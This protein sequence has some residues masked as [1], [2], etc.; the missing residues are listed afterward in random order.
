MKIN[1]SKL[2]TRSSAR[3]YLFWRASDIPIWLLG[4]DDSSEISQR[5]L[6]GTMQR[7]D[8]RISKFHGKCIV[9]HEAEIINLIEY[10][11][12]PD[13][14]HFSKVYNYWTRNIFEATPISKCPKM[15][16][17][18]AE[19][20]SPFGYIVSETASPHFCAACLSLV[21]KDHVIICLGCCISY[22][23][24]CITPQIQNIKRNSLRMC[25]KCSRNLKT[26]TEQKIPLR[27]FIY[28]GEQSDY[29]TLTGS[30]APLIPETYLPSN[31]L[32]P[33]YTASIPS[34]SSPQSSPEEDDTILSSPPH[35]PV[36][37]DTE[38]KTFERSIDKYSD[39][40]ST[41][42]KLLPHKS[43]KNVV[44]FYFKW[45]AKKRPSAI[46]SFSKYRPKSSFSS[47]CESRSSSPPKPPTAQVII[48]VQK[49]SLKPRIECSNC[50]SKYAQT[51]RNLSPFSSNKNILCSSCA[52]YFLRYALPPK[53]P[54]DLLQKNKL[55]PHSNDKRKSP[56]LSVV[57]HKYKKSLRIA[58]KRSPSP[59]S[60][61]NDDDLSDLDQI[62][63][64]RLSLSCA[65]CLSQAG[66]LISCSFCSM[67]V[68]P[69]CFGARDTSPF[70]CQKCLNEIHHTSP[71]SYECI[72]CPKSLAKIPSRLNAVKRTRWSNWVHIFCALW[73]SSAAFANSS[74][75]DPIYIRPPF[76]SSSCCICQDPSGICSK[77]SHKTCSTHFHVACAR[78]NLFSFVILAPND[79][80][81]TS[82][83]IFCGLHP[84][85]DLPQAANYPLD[86]HRIGIYI[87]SKKLIPPSLNY[88]AKQLAFAYSSS[89]SPP[90]PET[91]APPQK[92]SLSAK[93]VDLSAPF[94]VD[95]LPLQKII[96]NGK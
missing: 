50:A 41:V 20:T 11:S 96:A 51:Y 87:T 93:K 76:S 40:L 8:V 55:A 75:F 94:K 77:C 54:V 57:Q 81:R 34:I 46:S 86:D 65:V 32:G 82:L 88:P 48:N 72:L 38:I 15:P 4:L 22:H 62:P 35:S 71:C 16:I 19:L 90:S 30:L 74:H 60:S 37:S 13:C 5:L 42:S 67:I 36:W 49:Y 69:S 28:Y 68:H 43:T 78:N 21:R 80:S 3:V 61:P 45:L 29:S 85:N 10:S 2:A 17:E 18:I 63:A 52:S 89:T 79:H 84:R 25:S 70:T 14:F 47:F 91:P 26:A 64:G 31:R 44:A 27:P 95:V 39:N 59:T 92:T 23:R 9:K 12:T 73:S 7:Q 24:T 53:I 33:L 1:T 83:A 58:Q 66:T 56:S 6:V